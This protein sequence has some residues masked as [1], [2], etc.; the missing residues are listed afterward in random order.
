MLGADVIHQ[1]I[2]PYVLN[3]T[4]LRAQAHQLVIRHYHGS[5]EKG[6]H[7]EPMFD[8]AQGYTLVGARLALV[9][10]ARAEGLTMDWSPIPMPVM[11]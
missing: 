5:T 7:L 10:E 9:A 3:N 1:H 6:T 11:R 2:A 8:R 4:G